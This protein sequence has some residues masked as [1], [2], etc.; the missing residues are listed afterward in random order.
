MSKREQNR[1]YYFNEFK[2]LVEN[3]GGIMLSDSSKYKNNKSKLEIKCLSGHIFIK[4]FDTCKKSWC[5]YCNNSIN[6]FIVIKIFE[7]L[8]ERLFPKTRPKWLINDEGNKLEL[9]GY[10]EDLNLAVEVNGIQHYKKIEYFHKDNNKFI[11]QQRHDEIKKEKCKEKNIN[12]IIIPYYIQ[13]NNLVTYIIKKCKKIGHINIYKNIN[14]I[15][16]EELTF[17]CSK[18]NNYYIKLCSK[19]KEKKGTI[20]KLD[21]Y[22]YKSI[23]KLQCDKGH[24]WYTKCLNIMNNHWCVRCENAKKIEPRKIK[25]IK[26]NAQEFKE[27][28]INWSP[29]HIKRS[30]TMENNRE[31][32]RNNILTKKCNHCNFIKEIELFHKKEQAKDGY[33]PN[34]KDCAN[35]LKREWREKRKN[36]QKIEL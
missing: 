34:C 36:R 15:N 13:N 21:F 28:S 20:L 18:L 8:F 1:L 3:K 25:R 17:S 6:E 12:L 33:Q 22:N 10:C 2:K 31:I 4:T 19:I 16:L 26:S 32:L 29:S 9:D 5:I 27:Y 35:K 11:K 30:I 23:V 14:K 24:I 7:I